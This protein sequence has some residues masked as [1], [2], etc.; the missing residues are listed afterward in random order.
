MNKDYTVSQK[1]WNLRDVSVTHI[2]GRNGDLIV[3]NGCYKN[4]T[5]TYALAK[6]FEHGYNL[7]P[8]AESVLN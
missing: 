5:R 8:S 2:P 6:Y 1:V 3:D 7:Q 4:V